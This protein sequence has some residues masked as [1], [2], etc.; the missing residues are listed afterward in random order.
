MVLGSF[1]VIYS[2]WRK[3]FIIVTNVI[4]SKCIIDIFVV[5]RYNIKEMGEVPILK[6]RTYR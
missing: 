1:F 5:I 4:L 2:V 3:N 6:G